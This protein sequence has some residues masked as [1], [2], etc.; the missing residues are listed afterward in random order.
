MASADGVKAFTDFRKLIEL[1][2]FYKENR[3]PLAR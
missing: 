1:I 3:G 2:R